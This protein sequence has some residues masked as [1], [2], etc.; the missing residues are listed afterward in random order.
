MITIQCISICL[1]VKWRARIYS[2]LYPSIIYCQ[3]RYIKKDIIYYIINYNLDINYICILPYNNG[4][5][6]SKAVVLL[7]RLKSRLVWEYY[8]KRNFQRTVRVFVVMDG[9]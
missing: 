2:Y 7:Y 1:L 8:R 5:Y 6:S 3:Y 9:Q 4:T